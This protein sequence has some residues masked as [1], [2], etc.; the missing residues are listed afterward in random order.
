MQS[1]LHVVVGATGGTGTALVRELVRRGHR[2]RAV[3]R[4]G[5]GG[6]PGV[7]AVAADATDAGRMREVCA[8][9]AAVYNTV[10][11]PFDRWTEAFP[12]AVRG[13]LA[14]AS[15]AGARLVF[16]DDTWMYGRVD[17]PMTE[18]TPVRPV[19]AKGVL[20]AWL[21]EMVLAAHARGDCPTVIARAGE[22]YGPRVDSVLGPALFGAAAAG[23]PPRWIGALD[24]PLTPTFVEDFAGVLAT[25]GGVPAEDLGRVWHVPH[26]A[27]TTGHEFVAELRRRTGCRAPL[28]R[29]G[30]RTARVLGLLWPLAREGAELV[31]QFEMPFV[32]DGSAFAAR[33]GFTPTP[34]AEGIARTLGAAPARPAAAPA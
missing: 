20:R 23:R 5:G 25:L 17:A 11:P 3:S 24:R 14:G 34:Y 8:G 28:V 31:Y 9:A 32:V 26:P 10:N 21:A 22:L 29:V 12:A 30:A 6:G 4:G 7:D 2:V 33:F 16:A 19:S 15:S 13:T 18:A 27:P 1:E